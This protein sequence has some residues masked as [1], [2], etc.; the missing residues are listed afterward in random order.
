MNLFTKII[1]NKIS[2]SKYLSLILLTLLSTT[3]VTS[4]HTSRHSASKSRYE[5]RKEHNKEISNIHFDGSNKRGKRVAQEARD[6]LGTP[7]KYASGDKGKGSDCSGMVMSVYETVT[8]IKLPRNSAQ[9]AAFC[10]EIDSSTLRI[11][12]LCFFA[13]GK[14]PNKISH[15]GIMLDEKNFIHAST[16]KGVVISDITTPYYTRTFIQFGRVPEK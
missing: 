16:S 4:C 2:F 7:Y 5:R 6:W 11:G 1:I 8:G 13:T 9:Q 12:D 14:D 3:F 15:V 10:K